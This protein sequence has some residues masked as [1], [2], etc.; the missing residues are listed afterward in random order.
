MAVLPKFGRP[1]ILEILQLS[2]IA[3]FRISGENPENISHTCCK[4]NR[5]GT[6]PYT[7]RGTGT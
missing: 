6:H 7:T 2:H 4:S 1:E 3:A 5:T